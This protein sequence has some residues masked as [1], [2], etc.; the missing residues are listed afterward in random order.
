[1]Q[2]AFMDNWLQARGTLLHGPDYFPPLEAVGNRHAQVYTSSPGGGTR[3]MQAMYL[4]S[5]AASQ[6]T[7]RLSAA[8][9]I[10][11][12]VSVDTFIAALRRG[13]R[14]QIILPGPHIDYAIVGAASRST[15][16]KLLQ[17]GAEIYLYQPTMYHCKVL[18]VD[19]L[20]TSVGSTNFDNRSFV[21]NDEANLNV[22]D[23]DFALEQVR[24]F[25]R[26]LA[27]S[28]RVTL[29]EW[30]GRPWIEKLWSRVAGL[31]SSQL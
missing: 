31:L 6:K 3:S 16:G 13:V 21:I 9:F 11:D 25:E 22:Y 14:V 8:Y 26:D 17:A 19:E 30:Q 2:A 12:D 24:M 1:M 4:L 5:L 28:R 29:A 15:W 10:P 27:Q 18:I 20:W 23:R 7:I